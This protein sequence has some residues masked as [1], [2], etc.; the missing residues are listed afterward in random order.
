LLVVDF[1]VLVVSINLLGPIEF[2]GEEVAVGQVRPD[3]V[4]AGIEV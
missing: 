2:V 1:L 3:P 4:L